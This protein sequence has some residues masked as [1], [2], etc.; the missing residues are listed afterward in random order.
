MN[1]YISC[2]MFTISIFVSLIIYPIL[3]TFLISLNLNISTLSF[4]FIHSFISIQPFGRFWQ[5]PEPS[6]GDRYGSG[7]LRTRQI[8]RGRFSALYHV[9]INIFILVC[10][11]VLFFLILLSSYSSLLID[12]RPVYTNV[13]QF[14]CNFIKYMCKKE[15]FLVWGSFT[16][17]FI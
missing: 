17:L 15:T 2:E 11:L 13:S 5:E 14:F 3:Y 9:I 7:T 10:F 6:Q 16:F 4:C 1:A 8:L 12:Q